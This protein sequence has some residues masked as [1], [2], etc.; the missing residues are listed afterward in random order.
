MEELRLHIGGKEPKPGWKILNV[1]PGPA[2]DFV[3]NLMDMSRF[4]ED[5]V[6]E[7]YASHV[8][9]HI[10]FGAVATTLGGLLRV[11]KPG[12][13]LM[14]SVPDLPTVCRIY[15]DPRTDPMQ[16]LRITMVIYGSH[17]DEHDIHHMGYD[18]AILTSV[19]REAGFRRIRRVAEFG[20]FDDTSTL[21]YFGEPI[22][23]NVQ[24]QKPSV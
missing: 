11:L 3:G 19:L 13:R 1:L 2:V 5:S 21:R 12:G 14:L 4:A 8:L 22:S 6:A 18:E 23:L 15:N 20:L 10:P 17:V 24:A 16:R 9:E 7:I